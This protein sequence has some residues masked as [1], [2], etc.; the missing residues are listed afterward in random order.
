MKKFWKRPFE[1][2]DMAVYVLVVV[3]YFA[4]LFIYG[5][6]MSWGVKL[7]VLVAIVFYT[8]IALW[9]MDYADAS[10]HLAVKILFF[11]IQLLLA[12][13]VFY[14]SNGTTWLLLLPLAAQT[15]YLFSMPGMWISNLVIFAASLLVVRFL[16]GNWSGMVQSGV[17]FIAAQVFVLIFTQSAR[18]ERLARQEI[19][20]LA[21]E[22]RQANQKQRQYAAQVEELATL[23]ERNRLAREIHD[24]L[25]HYL[26]ALN[27]QLKAAQ[28]VMP[29]DT[30]RAQD[31]L[32]KAQTLAQ[33]ALADVRRSVAALKGEPLLNRP[34]PEAIVP[35]MNEC[36]SAG[37]VAEL[38][39][40]GTYRPLLSQ[41]D[42]TLYRAVQEALTNVRKHS[43]AS[44]VD[45]TLDYQAGRVQLTIGD[46]GV[47]AAQGD[48]AGF[49]LYGLRE[50]AVLL[51]GSVDVFTAP[52]Q[53]F[54]LTVTLPDRFS[55]KDAS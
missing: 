9:G 34:L 6:E 39:V 2:G 17:A 21:D 54:R 49:G 29:Q 38:V 44:R 15:V 52:K 50:R 11:S 25:G 37:L 27:M 35:L 5:R 31:A 42:F 53:G 43:L 20:R 40:K 12:A 28:A 48:E 51:G 36:R 30:A 26:T 22:L 33:D 1:T 16:S 3:S 13:G 46:N 19:E 41:A 10:K 18:N 45:V 24:G 7:G 55:E 23:Q 8:L 32:A 47:G 14:V 4:M